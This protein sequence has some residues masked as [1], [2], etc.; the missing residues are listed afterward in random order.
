MAVR[1]AARPS[2]LADPSGPRPNRRRTD[3]TGLYFVLPFFAFFVA[4][5]IW[6]LLA[7]LGTSTTD[8]GLSTPGEF[9]GLDNFVAAFRDPDVWVSLGNTLWFTVLSTPLLVGIG[10]ILALLVHQLTPGRWFWRLSFFAPFLLP[11]TVVS[12][13]FVWIFQPDFGLADGMLA[14]IGLNT[15]VGWLSD[16]S[17]AMFSIV[18]TTTWWT[19]GFNFLL[20]LAALQS[21]PQEYYEAAALDGAD[22]WRQLWRIT[23]PLLGRTTGLVLV[24][25]LLAS[26]KVFDQI[27]LMTSGGPGNST[28]PVIQYVYEMGFTNFGSAMPPRS[29]TC[30]SPSC[31]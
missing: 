22:R 14:A 31:W 19:V 9:V 7:G 15:D 11:A 25:Q 23:L 20:Y 12:L 6:P 18:L 17:M 1:S 30:S 13:I 27:Y 21:I 3:F 29:P 10:L 24:L 28:I 8:A 4:F 16:P 5:L 26:L 2:R